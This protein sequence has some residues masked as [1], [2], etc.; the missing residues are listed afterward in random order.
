MKDSISLCGLAAALF[1]LFV[2]GGFAA[3]RTLNVS[4]V[5]VTLQDLSGEVDIFY[6]AMRLNRSINA[7]NVEVTIRNKGTRELNGPFA[8][9]VESFSGT[10]GLLQPDAMD[11]IHAYFDLGNFVTNALLAPTQ[12]SAPRTLTLGHNGGTPQLNARVYGNPRAA[13]GYALALSRSL[14]EVGQPLPEVT[15]EEIGPEGQQTRTTD[16]ALG[17]VTLGQRNGTHVWKFNRPGYLPVWRRGVLQS[18]EVAVVPN[19][20]LTPL[21]TNRA[22][23]TPIAGGSLV[24]TGIQ[25][26][27]GPGAF[28]HNTTG[29]IARLTGQTLPA[30]LPLG[31]SPLQALAFELGAIPTAPATA[32][33]MP[34]GRV[35]QNETAAL[36]RWNQLTLQWDVLETTSGS[37]NLQ[38]SIPGAGAF[39]VVV[40]DVG[41]FAPPAALAGQPLQGTV[42]PFSFSTGLSA[43]GT[44]TPS[45][46]PASRNA[47]LVTANAEVTITNADGAM[48]SG[49]VL[50]CE[51]SETYDLADD[52]RRVLPRYETFVVGYQRPGDANPNTIVAHFPMR[53]MLLLGGDELKQGNV[54]V[55]VIEPTSF[56]GGVFDTNGGQVAAG[57]VR[58]LA[59]AGVFTNRLAIDL[60]LLDRTNFVG[61][62]GSNIVYA[63]ELSLGDLPVG[64]RLNPQFNPQAPNSF[65]VLARVL[66]RNGL[67]GLEPIERFTSDATGKLTSIE[68]SNGSGLPGLTSGGQFVLVRLVEPQGLVQG[69]ARNIQNQALAGIPVRIAAQPWLT[70]SRDGG[71]YR[72]IAPTGNVEVTVMDLGTGDSTAGTVALNNWQTGATLNVTAMAAG[73]RVV[74]VSPA[75]G[76]TNVALVSPVTITFSEPVNVGSAIGNIILLGA[77]NAP[78]NAALNFNLRGDVAS[79]LPTDPLAANTIH[80][81]WLSTNLADLAGYKLEGTNVFVFK[82]ES[83]T[84]DRGLGAQLTSH[85]PTNGVVYIRSTQGMAEPGEPVVIVNETS[86]RTTT[87]LA[88][89]DGSFDATIPAGVDDV[90]NAVF[91]N[92]NG[93]RNT[94]PVSQQIFADGS[95]GLFDGGG[96][97]ETPSPNGPIRLIVDPGSIANKTVIKAE[98]VAPTNYPANVTNTPPEDGGKLVGAFKFSGRGDE[99]N[100]GIDVSFPVK[101]EDLGLPQGTDPT[102]ASFALVVAREYIDDETGQTNTAYEILDRMHYENGRLVTHSPPFL[103]LLIS[104]VVTHEIIVYTALQATGGTIAIAGNVLAARPS[105]QNNR[106]FVPGTERYLPGATVIAVPPSLG[107]PTF[108]RLRPGTFYA[109]ANGTNAHFATIVPFYANGGVTMWATHPRFPGTTSLSFQVPVLSPNDRFLIGNLLYPTLLMFPLQTGNELDDRT[110]PTLSFSHAPDSPQPGTNLLRVLSRD[111]GSRPN[112]AVTVEA[113][114]P[115]FAGTNINVNDISLV[116]TNSEGVGTYGRRD[117]IQVICPIAAKVDFKAVSRDD[118][119]NQRTGLYS[120]LIGAAPVSATNSIPIVDP[121]DRTGPLVIRSVPTRGS[122]GLSPGQPILLR[123]DE[124]IDRAVLQAAGAVLLSPPAGRPE[125]HLSPDQLELTVFY[126]NLVPNQDYT[127]TLTAEVKDIAGNRL[128]QN[129]TVAG[130][131]SFE[132]TFHTAE[133]PSTAFPGLQQGGGAVV[134][135]IYAYVLERG[136]TRQGVMIYDLS[137]PAAPVKVSEFILQG[138]PR[139]LVLIPNYSFKTNENGPT[140]TH[141]LLAVVGGF[142]GQGRAQYLRVLDINDPLNPQRVAGATLNYDPSAVASRVQWSAPRLDYLENATRSTVNEINLQEMIIADFLSLDEFRMMPAAGRVGIDANGDGD[143]VDAGDQ[144]PLPPR[145]SPEFGGKT[146]TY[147]LGETDQFIT[148]FAMGDGGDFIGVTV[149]AGRNTTNNAPVNAAYRT[150]IAGGGYLIREAASYE[151]TNARPKRVSL[152][153]DYDVNVNGVITPTDFAL[154]S[155]RMNPGQESGKTN[156][157]VVLNV[158]DPQ[159]VQ[160]VTEIAIPADNGGAIFGI[161]R[162]EDGLLMAA[163]DK[164]ILLLDPAR[165]S[166]RL[167]SDPAAAHPAIVGVI[168]GAGEAMRTFDGNLAGLN[169]VSLGGKNLVLQSAPTIEVVAFPNTTPFNPRD[170]VNTSIT[171]IEARFNYLERPMTLP[172]ARFKG[173]PGVVDSTISPPDGHNHFY[174]LVHAP[175]SAG[176][177]IELA[178]ESLN[179]AGNP[180]PKKGFL[181]PPVNALSASALQGLGQTP[182]ASDAPP[183]SCRAWRLSHNPASPYYNLYLS[184][185][186]ALVTEEMS[187]AQLATALNEFDREIL[188]SGDYARVSIDPSMAQNAVLGHFAGEINGR[189]RVNLPGVETILPTHPADYL[190]SQNPGPIA[191]GAMLPM[192]M[193]ALRAHSGEININLECLNLPGRRLPIVFRM[194]YSGQSLYE[195]PFSRGWDFNYNQ[196]VEELNEALF[197][198]GVKVPL[199]IRDT[200]TN[201]EIAVS[202]DIIFHTGAGRKVIY[203]FAGTNAPA[204]IAA[205]PLVTEL[206]WT[207]LVARYY[208]PPEGLFNFFVKFKDGRFARLDTDGTQYW[209]NPA[210]KLQKA[211]DRY[212]DNSLEMVYGRRGE[213][214]QIKDELRRPVNIGYYRSANDPEFRSGIDQIATRAVELGKICRLADYSKRDLLFFY[215]NEG[216]LERR[217]GPK[218]E[219]ATPGS[220]TG[221][222]V[223]RFIYSDT[224]RPGITAQSLIGMIGADDTGTPVVSA[225]DLGSKGRDAV[226]KFKVAN[227][228]MTI[229]MTHDNTASALA[230]GNGAVEVTAADQSKIQHVF[231]KFGRP[232]QTTFTG[233]NGAPRVNTSTYYPNGL[234]RTLTYPEGNSIT[235]IY[236][237][238][239]P[240][241]R[242]RGNLTMVIKSPGPRGGPI[243]TANTQYDPWYNLAAGAKTD[244]NGVP[245]QIMLRPDHRDVQEINIA[246]NI[247]RFEGNDLGLQTKYVGIDGVEQRW[248]Y[249]PEG[250]IDTMI[251]GSGA[252]QLI[253]R[254]VYSP[255]GSFTSDQTRRGLASSI[256][257]PKTVPMDLVYDEQNRLVKV[258]RAGVT[259]THTYDASGNEIE[260]ATTLDTNLK[261]VERRAYNQLGFMTNHTVKDLEI[262]GGI[263]DKVTTM[264]PDEFS[265]VQEL[266]LPSG[267]RQ[268]IGYDHMGNVISYEIVGSYT[269]TYTYDLNGNRKSKTIGGATETY[270]YDGHDRMTKLT[271]VAGTVTDTVYDNNG[272]PIDVQVRDAQNRL[273]SHNA[274]SY[275]DLSRPRIISRDRD[276]GVSQLR[277]DFN[278]LQRSATI[279]D[280]LGAQTAVFYDLAGRPERVITPAKTNYFFYDANDN[281]ERQETF[282]GGVTYVSRW[283]RDDRDNVVRAFDNVGQATAYGVRLDGANISV[284]DRESHTTARTLSRLGE[285]LT[286]T[287]P[288]S[289]VKRFAVAT[290]GLLASIKDTAFNGLSYTYSPDGRLLETR[291]PNNAT[292]THSD[293]NA[294]SLPQKTELPRGVTMEATYSPVGKTL[295]RTVHGLGPNRAEAYVYDGMQRLT[296]LTDP[297]GSMQMDFDVFGFLKETRRSYSLPDAPSGVTTLAFA[298]KQTPDA[299]GNLATQTYPN[300]SSSITHR[301]DITGRLIGLD[302]VS[303]ETLVKNTKYAGDIRIGERVFGNDRVRME[304]SFDALRRVASRRYTRVSDGQLLAEVR[305]AFDKNGAQM[306]RQYVHRGGRADFFGYDGGYRL[307]RVDQD[308]RPRLD[309]VSEPSRTLPNFMQPMQVSGVWRAGRFAREVG[310]TTTDVIQSIAVYNPD[311]LDIAPMG[312]NYASPDVFRHVPVIDGASRDRD[313]VGNVTKTRLAVRIPGQTAPQLVEATLTYND[314]GQCTKITRADGVEIFN[315]YDMAGLRIRRR[316]VGNAARCV[317]SD[318]AFIYDGAK[319]IEERDLSNNARVMARYFYGADADELVAGDLAVGGNT[320]LVRH[321]FLGDVMRSVMAVTDANG[322]VVERVNY[323]A[324]GQPAVQSA[325][326]QRPSISRVINETNALLIV[327]TEPVLPAFQ[328]SSSG[329]NIITTLRSLN[330]AFD[331]RANNSPVSVSVTFEEGTT[332]YPFGSVFRL[333]PSQGLNGTIMLTVQ[334]AALQDEWN[335]TNATETVTWNGASTNV[336][337]FAGPSPGSTA[338]IALSRSISTLLFH[339]QVFDFD[340][341]LL[342]CR[343]RYYDPTTAT[344]LQRDPA[345]FEDSVNQYAAFANNPVNF[346]D[347]T[348]AFAWDPDSWGRSLSEI[349]GQASMKEDGLSG[350]MIGG[351]ISFAGA[352]LQLGTGTAEGW[353]LLHSEAQGTFGLLDRIHGSKLVAGD[354]LVAVGAGTAMYS[355]FSGITGRVRGY[356]S[357]RRQWKEFAHNNGLTA[358]EADA[359]HLAMREMSQL[360]KARSVEAGVRRFKKP[361]QRRNNAERLMVNKPGHVVD[362]T[363]ADGWVYKD[364]KFYNSDADLAYLEIDG[365]PATLAQEEHFNRLVKKHYDDLYRK[366][367]YKGTP[368]S[369]VQHGMHHHYPDAHGQVVNGHLVD[370]D[371]LAKVGHPGDVFALKFEDGRMSGFHKS[372]W[373][374]HNMLL[375]S[376]KRFMGATGMRLPQEWTQMSLHPTFGSVKDAA[377]AGKVFTPKR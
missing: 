234:L 174:V 103:G 334:G 324:W 40:A 99:V 248:T 359:K 332:G 143:F 225:T 373:Q 194:N 340:S 30:F 244:F 193:N 41:A 280:P 25:I 268:R 141:D 289:T 55:D 84:L 48:P 315:D 47:E 322:N 145:V 364:G 301:R 329:S 328:S 302:P 64:R 23:F 368:S 112:I 89:S 366:A 98:Y 335:N 345:G 7:W 108:G 180:L 249:T 208:L 42:A 27:F 134:R 52:T 78:V 338:P 137:N 3:E 281:L 68:P 205:D 146:G 206:G 125:L 311:Q 58:I 92:G 204:E 57:G 133:L 63:F 85:E 287:S 152:V 259:T 62:A 182:A 102:N 82:T 269:E 96:V 363:G 9:Y 352:V 282:E 24:T 214:M 347:P 69:I 71:A 13:S 266:I 333:R 176:D 19:P 150:L 46:S 105:N 101:V 149:E 76:S 128:D 39:A 250:F 255:V 330:G 348:G 16:G 158:T 159:D 278:P 286:E 144:L 290:N 6:S 169:V 238:N 59:A 235:Y 230:Q 323:D 218:I 276:G 93:T 163:T 142:V 1:S 185:P 308:V 53:P 14:N 72:L 371:K 162:R 350:Y 313:I 26:N 168:P 341:G 151:F 196:R 22:I 309:G 356:I 188:W 279:T 200:A 216:L 115:L 243:L 94:V 307:T 318:V 5:P 273:L 227:K 67:F 198:A 97:V 114:T 167:S 29:T 370:M 365:R 49:V 242:S 231:D 331:L 106:P 304:N 369:P 284:T 217:E 131:D 372:R 127:L 172:P 87:V 18:N 299:V 178:L 376:E 195:G 153:F 296:S 33:L 38:F 109:V 138:Y 88:K 362:K 35:A 349:G 254:Y 357:D 354:A 91:V 183:R 224:S 20:R 367:G 170:L 201:S 60:R 375:E 65:F 212:P 260:T 191:G 220:F 351:L 239:N 32:N 154:V 156:R 321:Y 263:V 261:L 221:R 342:Y 104:A 314:L 66:S 90:L 184:R 189:E 129:P 209:F 210:G 202:K 319:L 73:P 45:L 236:D 140:L 199:V 164:D 95:V 305:Y 8:L 11:G 117:W 21:G 207:N 179:W 298:I 126:Y 274:T 139:D 213:L 79:L 377:K 77:S 147:S 251:A 232:I 148:D 325:D 37:T 10:S 4:G 245:A 215:N 107:G 166:S 246:G 256:I 233:T 320:N 267:D 190:Q 228:Q 285:V 75:H 118:S 223:T 177:T 136:G 122:R 293:F 2:A 306:A 353:D 135:G 80:Q 12:V 34:W 100:G 120:M 28:S 339:G 173:E 253:T 326:N 291:L 237:T 197:L 86:G 51:V 70:F 327:F 292:I 186:F 187:V 316:V 123:F 192:A 15:V 303:G 203:K 229:A 31:W 344:F 113:A 121:H 219:A 130:N 262:E 161:A 355:V 346:R 83:E 300:N 111:D 181:F 81:L 110:P 336:V 288:N 275:D 44:V 360:Y 241:L 211:Y 160:L 43:L 317:P 222:A 17:L 337:L 124:P 297:S 361:V 358:M 270:E 132:L 165:F 240:V 116:W 271:T 312:T 155:I 54:Q 36:V 74:S 264:I 171:N 226:D 247:E 61:L 295:T 119:G 258:A 252:A 277:Y 374:M 283:E 343:A 265:R 50:R 272:N 310:Y 257:D 175:G 56:G 157:V 294:L